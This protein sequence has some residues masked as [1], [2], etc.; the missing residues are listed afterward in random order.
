VDNGSNGHNSTKTAATIT[1]NNNNHNNHNNNHDDNHNS[2][3]EKSSP[4]SS[5]AAASAIENLIGMKHYHLRQE[6]LQR[7]A[8]TNPLLYERLH[9]LEMERRMAMEEK[10]QQKERG[11]GRDRDSLRDDR[12]VRVGGPVGGGGLA[13]GNTTGVNTSVL[14]GVATG[15]TGAGNGFAGMV[16]MDAADGFRQRGFAGGAD[17]LGAMVTKQ[18]LRNNGRG[19]GRPGDA[20]RRDGGQADAVT[21]YGRIGNGEE[22]D[23]IS[24]V[25]SDDEQSGDGARRD[26][27]EKMGKL[28]SVAYSTTRETNVLGDRA[29]GKIPF[30]SND[31]E[32]IDADV[33]DQG[34][35]N[36]VR[37]GGSGQGQ[38]SRHST[39]NITNDN[40]AVP[41]PLTKLNKFAPLK[42]SDKVKAKSEGDNASA[43]DSKTP[44]SPTIKTE[45]EKDGGQASVGQKF[46][47]NRPHS[48]T[49]T[50]GTSHFS[51]M[52]SPGKRKTPESSQLEQAKRAK[53]DTESIQNDTQQVHQQQH[54]RA[55]MGSSPPRMT[56][57]TALLGDQSTAFAVNNTNTTCAV[58]DTS[59]KAAAALADI[60]TDPTFVQMIVAASKDFMAKSSVQSN[61]E[62]GQNS[63][64]GT[65]SR[66]LLNM[67][68]DILKQSL[69]DKNDQSNRLC[70]SNIIA[71]GLGIPNNLFNNTDRRWEAY[72]H[73]SSDHVMQFSKHIVYQRRKSMKSAVEV[74]CDEMKKKHTFLI[75]EQM[76]RF[77]LTI[78][79]QNER[80][81]QLEE[82][83]ENERKVHKKQMEALEELHLADTEECEKEQQVSY[84]SN[85]NR[86]I[87]GWHG[88][89]CLI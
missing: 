32:S 51:L 55:P 7:C 60:R 78:D 73:L 12:N 82:Q 85:V 18:Q 59:Q 19:D 13:P 56:L 33:D 48:N 35:P 50:Y 86:F 26:E 10:E 49:P 41:N 65:F 68:D 64:L 11:R 20:N 29:G 37:G 5:A 36:T 6:A 3:D 2:T 8:M 69:D 67:D 80:I 53:L 84:L 54:P 28:N 27:A 62:M 74:A 88:L 17:I 4:T 71:P 45:S 70:I 63:L 25:D 31:Q 81:K 61:A 34:F 83:L 38:E 39:P 52:N 47:T 40:T 57:P 46:F 43:S 44:A 1:T 16:G 89:T 22:G 72:V 23:V 9:A 87:S 24:I 66:G 30:R 76:T 15:S 14:G 21:D 75:N 42:Q 58:T 79:S 77:Q